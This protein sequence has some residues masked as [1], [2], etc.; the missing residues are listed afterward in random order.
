MQSKKSRLSRNLER[1]SK[2]QIILSLLGIVVIIFLIINFGVYGIEGLGYIASKISTNTGMTQSA[3]PQ[4]ETIVPPTLE[5]VPEGVQTATVDIK[6]STYSKGGTVELSV[7]GKRT[8]IAEVDQTSFT[9]RQVSL[10]E[11]ENE[12]KVRQRVND[13]TSEYSREYFVM[14][15]KDPPKLEVSFPSDGSTLTKGDQQINV[16]GKTDPQ[17]RVTVNTFWATVDGDGNFTYYL[18]LNDGENIITIEAENS[19]GVKTTKDI[20]VTF[21]P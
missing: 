3:E 9:F 19:A 8:K 16:T 7:N 17:N 15:A 13:K 12:I 10:K 14:Y 20:K 1:Q 4:V 2:K 21:S 18:K 6:G 11:G 5:N